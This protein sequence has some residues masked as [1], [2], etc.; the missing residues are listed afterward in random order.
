MRTLALPDPLDWSLLRAAA[1]LA[2]GNALSLYSHVLYYDLLAHF[3]VQLLIAPAL[4]FLLLR[5]TSAT[6]SGSPAVTL[7]L[8]FA[9]GLAVGAIWEIAE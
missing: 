8:I 4:Y 2:W 9:L 3:F 6:V 5:A 1:V 7:V